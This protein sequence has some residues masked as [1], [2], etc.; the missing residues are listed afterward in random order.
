MCWVG[1]KESF[2]GERG[3][4]EK[5]EEKDARLLEAEP[6]SGPRHF[7]LSNHHCY[8]GSKALVDLFFKIIA[9]PH[10]ASIILYIHISCRNWCKIWLP[11][12]FRVF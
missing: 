10:C 11:K 7:G 4:R 2:E 6:P 1:L 12:E 8:H 5:E 3:C 9:I